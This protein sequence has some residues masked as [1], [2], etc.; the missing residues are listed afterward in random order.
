MGGPLSEVPVLDINGNVDLS[1]W[2][3]ITFPGWLFWGSCITT[4]RRPTCRMAVNSMLRLSANAESSATE[5]M[6][7]HVVCLVQSKARW[8]PGGS[9]R[10][11]VACRLGGR[12][13]QHVCAS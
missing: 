9:P 3:C 1:T 11:S 6:L 8:Q 13:L 5:C 10:C 2:T 12:S 7:N 4:D